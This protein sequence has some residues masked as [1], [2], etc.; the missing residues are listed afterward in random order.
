MEDVRTTEQ[1][2][3]VIR[4]VRGDLGM[5]RAELSRLSGVSQRTIFALENGEGL[6]IGFGKVL[7]LMRPL[8]LV[9]SLDLAEGNTAAASQA[10]SVG[11]PLPGWYD[12]AGFWKLS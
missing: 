3:G 1:V 8:G 12:L 5:S 9:L 2:G 6:N 11:E 7:D 4:R 10:P